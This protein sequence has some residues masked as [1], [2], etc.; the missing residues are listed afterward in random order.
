M[1]KLTVAR[2]NALAWDPD[3]GKPDS[4]PTV[5]LV[6]DGDGLYLA[7]APGGSKSWVQRISVEGKRRSVGLGGYPTVSLKQARETALKN[8]TL[9]HDGDDPV[10]AKR[11]VKA[12]SFRDAVKAVFEM[13]AHPGW[14]DKHRKS[15]WS[16]M[17]RH[18][19]P[20]IG[21]IPVHRIDRHDVLGVLN[22]VPPGGKKPFWTERPEVAR[23]VRQRTAATMK[24]AMAHGYRED[25]PAG[26]VINWALPRQPRMKAHLRALPYTEVASA[27]AT[28]D[29]SQATTASKCCFRFLV[30]TAAR[31][32]EAR[33]AS[34]AEVDMDA[35]E[36]L[37]PAERM[38]GRQRH[39][40]PLT[41]AALA[42][43]VKARE[44]DDGSGLC[45]P[46]PVK[47]G[48]PISDMT[49]TKLLRDHGLAALTTVHGFRSA[50]RNWAGECTSSPHAVMELSLAHHVGS[51]VERAYARSDLLEKRRVLMEQWTA[52]VSGDERGKIIPMRG[53]A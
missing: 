35:R 33:G 41:D 5:Q 14:T 20:H 50:F 53:H 37:I 22:R 44:L 47:P 17:E 25:N 4:K 21:D 24:W 52:F 16:V 39:R 38:K 45:F 2:V 3:R 31:S 11:R 42:A 10:Q 9:V 30:L 28:V 51:D 27:L 8:R 19:L 15:W 34:W 23:R 40:V 49:L 32:G 7:L 13:Q 43:L 6:H 26:E 36:W 48:R 12:P 18:A 1:T 46:S 29:E